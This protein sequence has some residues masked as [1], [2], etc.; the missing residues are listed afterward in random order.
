MRLWVAL[1]LALNSFH[2][3]DRSQGY[4]VAG[5]YGKGKGIAQLSAWIRSQQRC[6]ER[7]RKAS[8][9]I[10]YKRT[11][12]TWLKMKSEAR[13]SRTL[14]ERASL[15]TRLKDTGCLRSHQQAC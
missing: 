3:C 14:Y 11:P 7:L 5:M 15:R 10:P 13:A 4:L 12:P 8:S 1:A 9:A 2:F 6:S